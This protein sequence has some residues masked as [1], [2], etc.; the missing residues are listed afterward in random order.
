MRK[1]LVL[2]VGVLALV[3][4]AVGSPI[5][6]LASDQSDANVLEFD[7]MAGVSGPFKG[8]TNAIRGVPG[9]GLAWVL[10]EGQGRLRADGR[11]EVHVRG[12]VLG[13]GAAAGTVPAAVVND[14]YRATVSCLTISGTAAATVNVSSGNFPVTAS[15]D[16]DIVATVDLPHPCIAP[17]VFVGRGNATGPNNGAWFAVTGAP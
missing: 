3:M 10:A 16:S 6:G 9:G 5:A 4:A 13:E 14:G 8:A 11:L 1:A 15:G 12:L 2:A 7:T 17:I